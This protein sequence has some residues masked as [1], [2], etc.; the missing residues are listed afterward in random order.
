[1]NRK[2]RDNSKTIETIR[3]I[4]LSKG[5]ELLKDERRGSVTM[6]YLLCSYKHEWWGRANQVKK[7]TWCKKCMCNSRR[8]SLEDL[9]KIASVKGF[10]CLSIEY[11]TYK[12]KYWWKCKLGHKWMATPHNIK[13]DIE[14]PGCPDCCDLFGNKRK[15]IEYCQQ[16]AKNKN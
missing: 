5:G 13:R 3:K 1:M 8:G 15:T 10:T 6:C 2:P 16:L 7:G 9:Q 12:T 11:K 14:T 4:A